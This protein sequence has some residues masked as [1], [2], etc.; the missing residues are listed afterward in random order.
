MRDFIVHLDP[1]GTVTVGAVSQEAA[2]EKVRRCGYR[3]REYEEWWQRVQE[4]QAKFVAK[5]AADVG[6][7]YDKIARLSNVLQLLDE[8]R[9][10]AGMN[11]RDQGGPRSDM[12]GV[13]QQDAI[14]SYVEHVAAAAKAVRGALGDAHDVLRYRERQHQ[15]AEAADPTEV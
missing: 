8:C 3:V 6:A 4:E 13:G 1:T 10:V 14:N 11:G 12:N 5:L 15:Q 7:V 9:G 2:E